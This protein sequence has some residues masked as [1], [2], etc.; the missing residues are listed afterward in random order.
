MKYDQFM[1]VVERECKRLNASVDSIHLSLQ[2]RIDDLNKS[3]YVLRI[4]S[5]KNIA[6]II[7]LC[8]LHNDISFL[9]TLFYLTYPALMSVVFDMPAFNMMDGNQSIELFNGDIY[10]SYLNC[11]ERHYYKE[12]KK[13][14]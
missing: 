13:G 2:F 3:V 4:S 5:P 10:R 11:G 12:V 9:G 1:K 6:Y 14:V 8:D 7:V